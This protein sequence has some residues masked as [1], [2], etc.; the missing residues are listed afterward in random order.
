MNVVRPDNESKIVINIT[1]P[2]LFKLSQVGKDQI[3]IENLKLK[4]LF[5]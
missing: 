2:T 4:L 5:D 1:I 3:D